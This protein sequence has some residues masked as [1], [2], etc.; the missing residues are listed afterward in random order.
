MSIINQDGQKIHRF[1]E[2]RPKTELKKM[3]KHAEE[4][5]QISV[6]PEDVKY[7][8]ERIALLKEHIKNKLEEE[9]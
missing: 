2:T 1:L 8:R 5:Y 4:Q 3:L 7:W 6:M 9:K